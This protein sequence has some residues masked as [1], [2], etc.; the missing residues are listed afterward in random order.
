MKT[1]FTSLFFVLIFAS[2]VEE[3]A[4]FSCDPVLNSYITAHQQELQQI[5]IT[6]LASA[7]ISYQQA[8]F[9]SF[10]AAKKR[11]IWLQK[12]QSLLSTQNY[13]TEEYTHLVNLQRHIQENYFTKENIDSQAN[14]RSQFAADWMM[15]AKSDLGWS[16]K[17]VAFVVY[18][19]YTNYA[20]FDAELNVLKS[21][22]KQ[23]FA[24]SEEGGGSTCNC[25]T[26]DDFC[27]TSCQ[28]TGCQ[29]TSGCGWLWSETCDGSCS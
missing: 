3:N 11:E 1:I 13:S 25:N 15:Y 8:V 22:Q 4:E 21:I 16:D 28:S 18:R 5:T 26:S 27:S 29:S 17:Y 14:E 9:R 24:N 10:D 19:L 12:I 7:D 23:V 20:Q 2:C 6:E